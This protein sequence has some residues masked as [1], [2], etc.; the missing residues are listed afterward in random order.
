MLHS[1]Q[2]EL[3]FDPTNSQASANLG[4]IRQ[5]PGTMRLGMFTAAN[6]EKSAGELSQKKS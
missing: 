4:K 3:S 6:S 1:L 2:W 5:Q